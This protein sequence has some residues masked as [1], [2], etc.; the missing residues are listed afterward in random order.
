MAVDLSE[1][2]PRGATAGDLP[3][4]YTLHT[5]EGVDPEELR[6]THNR[7]FAGFPGWTPWDAQMWRTWVTEHHA[8]RPA[9]G[10]LARAAD[11]EVAAYV[12]AAEFPAV[13][14]ATGVREAYVALVGTVPDHRRQGLAATLLARALD[15]FRR[16]GYA[17]AALDVDTE[18][19]SG[20]LRIYEA[21]G[22]RVER[23][24]VVWRRQ[25]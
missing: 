20:A 3:D 19:P 14:Q 16:A 15:G 18:N 25:G 2:A 22:F 17:R 10:L 9:L 7:A 13:E 5:W 1:P 12:R 8:S 21:A 11:G 4:G 6:T 24:W 23:R